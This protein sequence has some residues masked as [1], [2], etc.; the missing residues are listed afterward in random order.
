MLDDVLSFVSASDNGHATLG[1]VSWGSI[2]IGGKSSKVLTLSTT[3]R[4]NTQ[5]QTMARVEVM[6]NNVQA[7]A[8]TSISN[9]IGTGLPMGVILTFIAD[10]QEGQVGDQVGYTLTLTNNTNTD[11][12][13]LNLTESHDSR[14][15][16]FFLASGDGQI[17]P[18][19]ITWTLDTLKAYQQKTISIRGQLLSTHTGPDARN[20]VTLRDSAGNVVSSVYGDVA[21]IHSLPQTGVADYFSPMHQGLTPMEHP[22]EWMASIV[23]LSMII[24]SIAG[25]SLGTI[26]AAVKS[27][28]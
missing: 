11:A 24:T 2:V 23:L 18:G 1:S 4:D 19:H 20:T 15:I 22:A 8:T 25:V 3:V 28:S 14:D 5:S 26:V 12:T 13:G 10:K 6:A 16:N 7:V 9:R 17:A 21:F 27:R